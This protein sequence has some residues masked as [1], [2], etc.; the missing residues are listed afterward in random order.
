MFSGIFYPPHR[1]LREFVERGN[2][3]FEVLFLRVL[4]FVVADAV[5]ALDEHHHRRHT[6]AR[7]LGG[8]VQR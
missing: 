3:E 1:L 2:T 7:N 8:V 6:G 5:Q 4:D